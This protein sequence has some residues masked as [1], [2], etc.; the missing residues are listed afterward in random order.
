MNKQNNKVTY[1]KEE[2]FEIIKTKSNSLSKEDLETLR[3]FLNLF[4]AR[5]INN[6]YKNDDVLF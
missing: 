5:E 4:D 1:E 6:N 3:E 2:L